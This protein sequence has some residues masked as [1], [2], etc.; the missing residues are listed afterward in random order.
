MQKTILI[1][2]DS[3]TIRKLVRL[4]IESMGH[5]TIEASDGLEALSILTHTRLDMLITNLNMPNL[6]GFQL[7][8]QVRKK[9]HKQNLP[10]L[11]LSS[12]EEPEIVE[13]GFNAGANV[14]L[15]KPLIPWQL[16]QEMNKIFTQ[17]KLGRD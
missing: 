16:R 10:I 13:R 5:H 8:Q 3:A 14:Y 11:I 7:I 4:V 15:Y 17:A 9:Y 2:D 1:V 6:D 12:E